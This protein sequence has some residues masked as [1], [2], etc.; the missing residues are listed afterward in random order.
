MANKVRR[1]KSGMGGSRG[2]RGRTE[3]TA[4]MKDHSKKE[5]RRQQ[6]QFTAEALVDVAPDRPAKRDTC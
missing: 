4:V 1:I 6:D 3:K 2:G 5:R